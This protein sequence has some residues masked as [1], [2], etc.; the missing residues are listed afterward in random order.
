VTTRSIRDAA[1]IETVEADPHD[2]AGLVKAIIEA[3]RA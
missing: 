2:A 3:S 1:M